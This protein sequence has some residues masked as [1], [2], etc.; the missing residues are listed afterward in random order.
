MNANNK[1]RHSVTHFN[2]NTH[3]SDPHLCLIPTRLYLL[4]SPVSLANILYTLILC[5]TQLHPLKGV[6]NNNNTTII[7]V[8]IELI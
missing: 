5:L 7:V 4:I 3:S 2:I 8:E 6:S 1:A